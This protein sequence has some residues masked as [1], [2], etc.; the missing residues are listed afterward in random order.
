VVGLFGL[1]L[2]SFLNVII[3]RLPRGEQ[4]WHG[5]SR[6][7]HC[8]T[9]LPWYDN[10]PLLSYLRLRGRCRFCGAPI[11]LRYPVVEL[12]GCLLAVV[13]WSRFPL[14]SILIAYVPFTMALLAL[15]AIDLEH[16]LLPD[17]ITLPGIGLG[18]GLALVL[19]HIDFLE[20]ASGA[21]LGGLSLWSVGWVYQKLKGKRGLGG[22]DV[23]LLAM[24]G[25]FLGPASIP[26]VILLSAGLG[27]LVGLVMAMAQG[28]CRHGQWQSLS[29]PFGP[30]LS[31][32]ACIY[33]VA[34]DSL[35]RLLGGG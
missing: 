3:T 21:V 7:P 31:A 8:L 32:G 22:G 23:K 35:L 24:I 26:L 11:S 2:G 1:A 18:L 27:S 6:C 9:R 4:V 25:A 10:I 14:S 17:A 34:G 30:F 20:A 5:R 12:S 28:R 15:S 33:L 16:F 13:L 29:L 19:P